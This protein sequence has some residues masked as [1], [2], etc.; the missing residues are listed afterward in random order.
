ML[1]IFCNSLNSVKF[2]PSVRAEIAEKVLNIFK[3]DCDPWGIHVER[4]E[5]RDE[6]TFFSF[7]GISW[8]VLINLTY[9]WIKFEWICHFCILCQIS[10]LSIN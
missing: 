3:V 9:P 8:S 7:L 10:L 2:T 4:V 5:A 6:K 1:R